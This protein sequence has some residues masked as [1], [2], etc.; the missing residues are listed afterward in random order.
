M[1]HPRPS[2]GA[3]GRSLSRYQDMTEAALKREMAKR[4]GMADPEDFAGF[5][6]DKAAEVLA[7]FDAENQ[8][9]GWGG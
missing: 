8:S 6:K 2:R 9:D 7:K 5:E 4:M 3:Y 1:R